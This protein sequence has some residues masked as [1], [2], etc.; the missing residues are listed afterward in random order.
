MQS[1]QQQQTLYY[2]NVGAC[3]VHITL[4]KTSDDFRT[5]TAVCGGGAA[6]SVRGTRAVDP[7][8]LALLRLLPGGVL[9]QLGVDLVGRQLHVPHHRAADEAVL[10]RQ[11]RKTCEVGEWQ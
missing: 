3:I 10:H 4:E 6:A 1:A 5:L 9:Q 11:L 8:R 7:L 2:T